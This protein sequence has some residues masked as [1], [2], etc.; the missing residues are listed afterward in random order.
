MMLRVK[1]IEANAAEEDVETK[2]KEEEKA[3]EM[4]TQTGEK[5]DMLQQQLEAAQRT[6]TDI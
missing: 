1:Q 3:K 4:L 6:L 2:L 5:S